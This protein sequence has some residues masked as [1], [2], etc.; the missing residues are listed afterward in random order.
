MS[1]DSPGRPPAR[2]FIWALSLMDFENFRTFYEATQGAAAAKQ[3]Q[4]ATPTVSPSPAKDFL[5]ISLKQ[6]IL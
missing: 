3:W 1:R 2:E 6:S 5:C 4:N